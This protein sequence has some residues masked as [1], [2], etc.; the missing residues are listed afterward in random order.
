MSAENADVKKENIR[1]GGWEEGEDVR[2]VLWEEAEESCVK[3]VTAVFTLQYLCEG[4]A[5]LWLIP[6]TF[7]MFM[8]LQHSLHAVF[9]PPERKERSNSVDV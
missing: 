2:W 1:R 8:Q 6:N 5:S 9:L 7:V 4:N 3:W